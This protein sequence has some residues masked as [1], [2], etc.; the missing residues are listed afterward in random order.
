MSTGRR[1]TRA[2]VGAAVVAVAALTLQGCAIV[3]GS[4][5]DPNTLRVMM[6]A[7]T[8]YPKERKQ[9]QQETAA[10]FERTTGARIQWETYSSAQEELTAIQTSVISGQGPDVYAIGTT[11]TPTA[12]ATGAFVEMGSKEWRAVGGKDQFDAASLGISGPSASKQ[13]GIPFASRPFVMAVNKDLLA[14]AGIT[15]LP[16]TWDEL[17]ADAKATTRDGHFGMAIAYADGFDPWKFVWGMAQNAGNTIV[18]G[19]KAEISADAVENAYRTYFDWVTKDGVVDQ[20]AIGWNNAQA[21]AQFADGKAAFFPMTTTTSLNTLKGS[22]V[23]G[24]YEYALLP[25]VPPGATERPADGIEAASILSGDNLVVADYGKKQD[26]SF[27][28]V[29]QVSSPAAQERY[30]E[31]FGQLPTNTQAAQTIAQENPDLAPIVQA[32][33]LSKPTAFTGAWSDIQLSLVDVVVQS[34][35]SLKSGEVTDDQLRKRLDAA[36]RDAQ[37]TLD[38]QKNGG[39]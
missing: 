9:W 25:T 27:D 34:I 3:N 8:T 22:A 36:Q 5:D 10:E 11:F 26:L 32:G 12:Y 15:D 37:A 29:K 39:L 30:F 18:D 21:L 4:G 28:F 14:Q 2:L 6:G 19:S 33:K 13:I 35:P 20:A 16:T 17:T 1:R 38:R 23:D 7:D 31:L 24:K